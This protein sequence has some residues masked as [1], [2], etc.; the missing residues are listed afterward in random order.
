[1]TAC[2]VLLARSDASLKLPPIADPSGSPVGQ[3]WYSLRVFYRRDAAGAPGDLLVCCEFR[4]S[5][6]AVHIATTGCQS[7]ISRAWPRLHHCSRRPARSYL[8]NESH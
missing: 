7:V 1:M 8:K 4:R 3:N 5:A 6:L 2:E